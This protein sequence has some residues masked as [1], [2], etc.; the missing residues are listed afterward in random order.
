MPRII[1]GFGWKPDY[2]DQ[3]D[4]YFSPP[5]SVMQ[6]L[7]GSF[8]LTVNDP[9]INFDI[10]DQEQIGSCT[11]NALAAAVQYDCIKSGK[12]PTFVPSRLFLYYNER[13]AESTVAFDS[14]AYLRDGTNSL[15]QTGICAEGAWPY[16]P[17]EALFDGGPFPVGSKPATQPPQTAYDAAANYTITGYQALQQSL[18]QLQGAIVAG[19]PFVFGFTVYNSWTAP[20]PIP[21][22][23]PMPVATDS[24]TGGHAALAVGYDNATSLFKFRNSWGEKQGEAGYFYIPYSYITNSDLASDFW[25]INA[26]KP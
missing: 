9:R 26:V 4:Q 20:N 1:R 17:T 25:V 24:V 2:P 12:D 3:R 19:F 7:P 16:I 11:A 8:D 15:S 22:V 21:T 23:I 5:G 18:T 6:A 14:G 10:Y 13:V